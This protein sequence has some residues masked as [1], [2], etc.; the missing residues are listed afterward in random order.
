LCHC[1]GF[2]CVCQPYLEVESK[3]EIVKRVEFH[4]TPSWF[5][6]YLHFVL[7]ARHNAH[8][9]NVCVLIFTLT[10]AYR[11]RWVDTCSSSVLGPTNTIFFVLSYFCHQIQHLSINLSPPHKRR[12]LATGP[13]VRGFNPGRGRWIFKGDK[14]P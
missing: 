9:I 2:S 3:G 10:V 8:S 7:L 6:L 5:V 13:K 12:V 11:R 4:Q 14:N 1:G